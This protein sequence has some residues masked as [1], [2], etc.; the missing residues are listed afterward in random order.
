MK[1][2]DLTA[3]ILTKNESKNILECL[4]SIK[5]LAKRIVIVDSGSEDNTVE[6]AKEF[7]ADVYVHPF[8]NYARQFNWG[9]DNTNISTK[10][11]LRIDADERFTPELCKEVEKMI[12]VH[13]SD[14]V[15]GFTLEAWLYF[16]GKRLEHGGGRKRKLMIFKYGVGRIEDRKMDEHTILSTGR[17]IA[18]KERFIHYDF[19]NLDVL[20]SKYNWYATREM[21]DYYEYQQGIDSGDLMFLDRKINNKR[22]K[23]YRFYYKAPVFLR[24]WMLFIYNYIFKFGFLD[25]KEGYM[26]HFFYSFFYRSLVDAKIYEQKVTNAPFKET[27]DL[28]A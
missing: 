26:Y 13:D 8:E 14:D 23:K 6:I 27:G 12:E 16:M 21:Q 10:W 25:G 24:S 17:S 15:N 5:S 9:L 1:M 2:A 28:K 18:L 3:I 20:I 11:A 22:K 4:N 19:K 7:G